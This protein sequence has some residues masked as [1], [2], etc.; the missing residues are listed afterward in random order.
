MDAGYRGRGRLVP[1]PSD[2]N[3]SDTVR[4][5]IISDE[6]ERRINKLFAEIE[7]DAYERARQRWFYDME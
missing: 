5:V 3:L 4:V 1:K 2:L 6:E 7:E